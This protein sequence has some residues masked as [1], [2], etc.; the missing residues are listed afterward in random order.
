MT[1]NANGLLS[2]V[3]DKKINDMVTS[4]ALA[5]MAPMML[6]DAHSYGAFGNMLTS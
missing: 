5:R 3:E 4:P 1:S 6:Q 2:P